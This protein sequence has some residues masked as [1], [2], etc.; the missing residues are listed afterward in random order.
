MKSAY[1][2]PKIVA[3][4]PA[5]AGE[6]RLTK[7]VPNND[8]VNIPDYLGVLRLRLVSFVAPFASDS[9]YVAVLIRLVLGVAL[10][11]HGYPKAKGGW[12]QGGQWMRSVG[13]PSV[14]AIFATIIEFLG[15]ALLIVGLIVPVVSAFIVLQFASITLVKKSKMH[16]VFM[17]GGK[18]EP[19]YEIDVL[20]LALGLVLIVLGGGAL[21][22]DKLLG[23]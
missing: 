20:Y 6:A 1:A 8:L 17:S 13:V 10:V 5:L 22:L 4:R 11:K 9:D 2:D 3:V 7:L 19:S 18:G 16:A 21:S 12:K 23:A 15:G 14:T